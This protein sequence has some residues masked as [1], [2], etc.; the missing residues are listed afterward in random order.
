MSFLSGYRT[1][2]IAAL[3]IAVGGVET[4]GI[5]IPFV[6]ATPAELFTYALGLVFA[7]NGSKNDVK[8]ITG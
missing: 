7:R 8:K 4:L 2:I 5:D 6:T 3:I 1:Y